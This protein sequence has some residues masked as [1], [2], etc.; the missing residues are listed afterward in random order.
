MP[1]IIINE[2]KCNGCGLCINACPAA[3]LFLNQKTKK[4]QYANI[5]SCLE[6]KACE[7]QCQREAI[8]IDT[9]S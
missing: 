4:I 9:L 8:F 7:I 6:C 1:K 2:E 3:I 5:E